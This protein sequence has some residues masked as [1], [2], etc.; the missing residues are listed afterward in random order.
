MATTAAVYKGNRK[1]SDLIEILLRRGYPEAAADPLLK[2]TNK[3]LVETL[4]QSDLA[5][6]GGISSPS[7]MQD[8]RSENNEDG[9]AVEDFITEISA[10]AGDDADVAAGN[11]DSLSS[12]DEDDDDEDNES[13]E[14]DDDDDDDDDDCQNP[15]V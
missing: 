13:D 9:T 4:I 6:G 14:D 11:E 5:H 2:W 15:R 12:S 3:R 1:K 10:S 8:Q 7:Q